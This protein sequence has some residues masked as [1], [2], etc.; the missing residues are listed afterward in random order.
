MQCTRTVTLSSVYKL[1]PFIHFFSWNFCPEHISKS[2]KARNLKPHIHVE[3]IEEACSAQDPLL[4]LQYCWSYCPWYIFTVNFCPE[5]ISKSTKVRN[6]KLHT[7]I[8]LIEET[9]SAQNHDSVFSIFGVIA[10]CKF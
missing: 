10:L 4:C 1:L 8:E 9:C 3:L 2:M 5:H 7:Y 6:L